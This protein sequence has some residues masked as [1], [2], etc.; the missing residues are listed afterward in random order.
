MAKR[1]D[2]ENTLVKNNAQANAAFFKGYCQN[3]KRIE[4]LNDALNLQLSNAPESAEDDLQ[5]MLNNGEHVS[6]VAIALVNE[7]LRSESP[8]RMESLSGYLAELSDKGRPLESWN[9]Y[10]P[11]STS[12][13]ERRLVITLA[14]ELL[15]CARLQN[16]CAGNALYP[17][18][19]RAVAGNGRCRPGEDLLS[20]RRRT[21][22]PDL[23]QSSEAIASAMLRLK[24]GFN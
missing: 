5:R 6:D 8:F 12:Y 16:A 4:T 2:D 18:F 22:A 15:F 13:D 7:V 9:D 17:H 21:V 23:V 20:Y 14:S 1:I 19:Q 11:R 10:L 3:S 24:Y